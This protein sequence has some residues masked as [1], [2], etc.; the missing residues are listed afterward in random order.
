MTTTYEEPKPELRRREI[1]AGEAR[2]AVF[3]R[4]YETTIEDLWDACTNPERLARW[5]TTVTG[6]LQVGGT[7]QQ[8]PAIVRWSQIDPTV[9]ISYVDV[10]NDGRFIVAKKVTSLGGGNFHYEMAV[11]NLTSDR[12]GRGFT[13]NF[14]AGTV[15]SAG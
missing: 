11:H 13:V 3:T 6:D 14:P 12:S 8:V 9:A 15:I 1:A 4:T 2:V 10:P 5:Y 7:F